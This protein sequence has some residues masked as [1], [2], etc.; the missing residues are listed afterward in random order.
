[1]RSILVLLV[2]LTGGAFLLG[3]M[4]AAHAQGWL[5][6]ASVGVGKQYDY[7][8]GGPV[9]NS[10]DTDTA[11]RAFAGYQFHP[12]FAGVLSYVDLGEP[13]YS[14]TAFGGFTD[15]LGADGFDLSFVAG[16][17]PGE[18]KTFTLFA[19]VGVFRWKQDVHYVDLSGTYDYEDEGT[20]PSVSVGVEISFGA[21]G[22]WG[23]HANLQRF[24]DVGDEDNSGHEYD[25][26]FL[27]VGVDYRFGR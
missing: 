7:E 1:M 3:G 21:G 25:R 5:A 11:Y 23:L 8:V 6:G 26:D 13:N 9:E 10:D 2:I 12:N 14:G 18:Q 19:T 4:P 22:R 15:S 24:F 16:F 20:S 27:A 17:A